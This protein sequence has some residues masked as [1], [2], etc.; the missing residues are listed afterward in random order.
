MQQSLIALEGASLRN[1]P[2]HLWAQGRIQA[3]RVC[4]HGVGVGCSIVCV[5]HT[6]LVVWLLCH[7][8]G[9]L[10]LS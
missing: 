6:T 4:M 3:H 2:S 10:R 9:A 5:Q 8:L 7:V 1:V